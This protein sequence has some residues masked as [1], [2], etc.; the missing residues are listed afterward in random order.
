M[1]FFSSKKKN[2]K[3]VSSALK[4]GIVE[5][6]AKL[7]L[8]GSPSGK[9]SLSSYL[10]SSPKNE[11]RP[12]RSLPTACGSSDRQDQVKRNLTSEIDSSLRNEDVETISSSKGHKSKSSESMHEVEN[13]ELQQFAANF[14]SFYCR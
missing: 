7:S 8:E 1:Q 11:I 4:S 12:H 14:L 9:G 3:L 2:N 6:N 10:V 13:P 5:Q